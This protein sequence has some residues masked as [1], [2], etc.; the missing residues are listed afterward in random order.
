MGFFSLGCLAY[1]KYTEYQEGKQFPPEGKLVEVRGSKMHINCQGRKGALPAVIFES[2]LCGSSLDWK[3]VQPQVAK[4][5]QTITYDR[6]GYGWSERGSGPR[7][8]D[9]LVQELKELLTKEG[10]QPPCLFVCHSFGAAIVRYYHAQYPDEVQGMIFVEALHEY[11]KSCCSGTYANRVWKIASKAFSC[12]THFGALRFISK[13]IP[14]IQSEQYLA[15]HW[16]KPKTLVATIQE[17]D[18]FEASFG[19]L[20]QSKKPLHGKSIRVIVRERGSGPDIQSQKQVMEGVPHATCEVAKE[21]GHMVPFDCPEAIVN[22]IYSMVS[23]F[24]KL[25]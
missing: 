1:E 17:W 18:G 2:G 8:V 20:E 15:A 13:I 5:M 16:I 21:S 14:P 12:L 19:M 11:S 3:E 10:I 22:A 9:V 4:S 7:T 23:S 25:Y 6:K 24:K